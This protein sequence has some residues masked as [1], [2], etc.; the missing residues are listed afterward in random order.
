MK[1]V[2]SPESWLCPAQWTGVVVL[3]GAVLATVP[4][5][6]LVEPLQAALL[7]H[8]G[9]SDI[10]LARL[11]T[12]LPVLDVLGPAALAYL[13]AEDFAAAHAGAEVESLPAAHPDV[14]ALVTS[15]GDQD[16]D[17]SGLEEIASAAFVIRKDQDVI[18]AA[19][20]RPWLDTAAHLSVLTAPEY[21]GRGLARVVA[22]AAVAEALANELLPQWRARPDS[23]RRVARALGF[24]EVGSQV[25]LQ[26]GAFA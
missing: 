24:R 15:V 26:L 21:R 16:A 14:C 2:A 17:E 8:L 3:D 18:A 22:S 19:G 4:S 25:S 6:E 23:S 12:T 11:R 13:D 20:Y 7:E 1:V 9:E 5:A 10:D